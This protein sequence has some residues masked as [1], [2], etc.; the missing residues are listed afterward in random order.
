[1]LQSEITF[2][3]KM[4]E[5]RSYFSK[6]KIS[7]DEYR[8][9]AEVC[10]I[11]TI[12]GVPTSNEYQKLSYLKSRIPEYTNMI[13]R[14]SRIYV[15]LTMMDKLLPGNRQEDNPKITIF[16]MQI[17]IH[18]ELTSNNMIMVLRRRSI[19]PLSTNYTTDCIVIV[20]T[21]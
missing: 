8:Q 21:Q 17:L 4:F 5:I 15:P 1:M 12:D 13:Y 9:I 10:P 18:E 19:L 16:G 3:S 11:I 7:A 20:E 14:I 6:K 2:L